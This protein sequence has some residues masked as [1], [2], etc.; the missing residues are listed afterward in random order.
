MSCTIREEVSAGLG[1]A[2]VLALAIIILRDP[3]LATK[4]IHLVA[5]QPNVH[6]ERLD[7]RL[8]KE[9]QSGYEADSEEE[10]ETS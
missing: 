9:M 5:A 3:D 7:M 10:K 8:R 4:L 6:L 1:G 2:I